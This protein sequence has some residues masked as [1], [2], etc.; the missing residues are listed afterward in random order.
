MRTTGEGIILALLAGSVVAFSSGWLGPF[1]LA[2]LGACATAVLF[3]LHSTARER[4]VLIAIFTGVAL[5]PFAASALGVGAP[6][7]SFLPEGLLLHTRALSLPPVPTMLGLAY[8]S[9]SFLVLLC[10]FVGRL[11]DQQRAAERRLFVQAW[12]LRQLFPAGGAGE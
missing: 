9:V 7:Y 2:P 11:R 12:H 10:V 1:V 8:T 3:V 4:R 6:A 5:A